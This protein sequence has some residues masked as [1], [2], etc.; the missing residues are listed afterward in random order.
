MGQEIQNKQESS[1]TDPDPPDP[2]VFGLDP[3]PDS[4]FRSMDLDPYP[5]L[6]PYIN[7]QKK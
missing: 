5:N 3:D 6:D 2:H 4:P 1:V 7:K